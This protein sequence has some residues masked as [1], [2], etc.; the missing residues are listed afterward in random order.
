V[1]GQLGHNATTLRATPKLLR[2]KDFDH[3]AI[4]QVR[5]STQSIAGSVHRCKSCESIVRTLRIS[6]GRSL[7]RP[8]R[9]A[10][11]FPSPRL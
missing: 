3:E 11:R 6:G 8:F 2:A 10:R 4:A 7:T 1:D 5:A 9:E